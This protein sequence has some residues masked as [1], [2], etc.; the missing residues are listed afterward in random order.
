MSV[1][2]FEATPAATAAAAPAERRR[3]HP[4]TWIAAAAL[5]PLVC[6]DARQTLHDV[7]LRRQASVHHIERLRA[8]AVAVPSTAAP[9]RSDALPPAPAEKSDSS[10][11]MRARQGWLSALD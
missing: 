7:S 3:V 8:A 5:L 10:A 11:Q 1:E 9:L 4:A 2:C 6:W